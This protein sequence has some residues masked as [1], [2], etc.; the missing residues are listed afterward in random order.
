MTRTRGFSDGARLGFEI[1]CVKARSP[2]LRLSFGAI[3]GGP[4]WKFN[5][6]ERRFFPHVARACQGMRFETLGTVV[7]LMRKTSTRT[8][9]RA[10]VNVIRR[11][12]Q[13]G[14]KVA[15]TFKTTMTILF[16]DLLP[17]WNYVV[18]PQ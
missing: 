18:K 16:D 17:K 2:I 15:D 12:Y 11:V 4:G 3:V 5:P 6:I 13:T 7:H 10:T 8:G 1:G 9:L 14:R